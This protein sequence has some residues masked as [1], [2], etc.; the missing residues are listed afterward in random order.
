MKALVCKGYGSLDNLSIEEVPS[1][2]PKS[3]QVLIAAQ[4]SA[5]NFPDGLIVLGT[6]QVKPPLPFVPGGEVAGVVKAVGEGVTH[7]SPGT[8]VLAWPMRGAFAE[9]VIANADAVVP[10]Q[11][12]VAMSA[13]AAM[14][15]TYGTSYHALL[16]RAQLKRGETVL[17]LGAG[18]G[19]GLACVELGKLMGA[20]VIAAASST[21]KLD[22]AKACGADHLINYVSEDMR[23]RLKEIT[24]SK[25][26]DV[27]CDAVGAAYAE[28]A[29][30]SV[31]WG[32]RYLVIGFAGGDIPRIP[33]NLT[34]LK[35]S[36]IVGVF[37]GEFLRREPERGAREMHELAA[38]LAEGRIKP[39][40]TATYSLADA[41]QALEALL[42]RRATG[43]LV[44]TMN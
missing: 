24:G 40:V 1:P 36:A 38:F 6:Y 41:R 37:W 19:V 42:E 39:R 2:V 34:L 5:V 13:A 3:G 7:V 25:G 43:K 10:I 33:L 31:G 14:P 11:Q 16:D 4:A 22:A 27:V 17:V 35:G 23:A 20:T 28:P 21:E 44:I 12:N 26:V 30:R 9:E 15:M 32:G 29:L 18:G 8:P